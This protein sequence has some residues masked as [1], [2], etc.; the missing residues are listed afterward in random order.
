[1]VVQLERLRTALE[2]AVEF[3][4]LMPLAPVTLNKIQELLVV[5]KEPY[6]SDEIGENGT[7]E[8]Y[9]PSGQRIAIS[10]RDGK[11]QLETEAAL[12]VPENGRIAFELDDKAINNL[13]CALMTEGKRLKVKKR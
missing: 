7:L 5:L 11:I 6:P 9:T 8:K 10:V 1:M 13:V 3:L 12:A 2:G 4:R